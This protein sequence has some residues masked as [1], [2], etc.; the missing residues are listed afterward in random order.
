MSSTARPFRIRKALLCVVISGAFMF[1]AGSCSLE[2]IAADLDFTL[3]EDGRNIAN[4]FV[5]NFILQP[6]TDVVT[7]GINSYFDRF[8]NSG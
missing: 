7:E 1:Q 6:I 5:Q 2:Q 8:G 4:S 3:R